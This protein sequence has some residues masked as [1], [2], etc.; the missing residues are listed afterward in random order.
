MQSRTVV[1]AQRDDPHVLCTLVLEPSRPLLAHIERRA[2]A[3][4]MRAA[5]VLPCQPVHALPPAYCMRPCGHSARCHDRVDT[6]RR[7]SSG[8]F[9]DHSQQVGLARASFNLCPKTVRCDAQG[10]ICPIEHIGDGSCP[11]FAFS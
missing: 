6:P 4:V 1:L 7:A 9:L 3:G 11:V 10:R 8:L 2:P 5:C